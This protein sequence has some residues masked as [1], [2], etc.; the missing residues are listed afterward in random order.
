M[1]VN[2]KELY[3]VTVTEYDFGQRVLDEVFYDT[4]E[5]ADE[6]AREINK[7]PRLPDSFLVADVRKIK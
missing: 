1:Q 3:K 6:Y 4:R 7:R 2:L 5:E